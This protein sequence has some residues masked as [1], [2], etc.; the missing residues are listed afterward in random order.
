MKHLKPKDH[1]IGNL[2]RR[3]T[4]KHLLWVKQ[5]GLSFYQIINLKRW[6]ANMEKS[7]LWS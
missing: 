5:T 2:N 1:L 7:I 4:L 3:Q 6:S